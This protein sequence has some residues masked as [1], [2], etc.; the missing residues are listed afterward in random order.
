MRT[1]EWCKTEFESTHEE[2]AYCKPTHAKKANRKRHKEREDL[3]SAGKCPTPGKRSWSSPEQAALFNLPATQYL[4]T[5]RCGAIHAATIK[6]HRTVR[7][8]A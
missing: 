2:Q 7:A 4:Y 8:E 5:C 6:S 1:C 3:Q